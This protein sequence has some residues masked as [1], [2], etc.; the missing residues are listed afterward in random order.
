MRQRHIIQPKKLELEAIE[1]I[2]G[3]V[4]GNEEVEGKQC[5]PSVGKPLTPCQI[6]FWKM[7]S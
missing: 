4:G 2:D 6:S 5:S 7:E 1:V 3:G